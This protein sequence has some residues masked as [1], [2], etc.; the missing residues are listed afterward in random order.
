ML[1]MAPQQQ[2]TRQ[3]T[4]LMAPAPAVQPAPQLQQSQTTAFAPVAPAVEQQP[5]PQ[6]AAVQPAT[7]AP[8]V[9]NDA[10]PDIVLFD[11]VSQKKAKEQ[12]EQA[13]SDEISDDV[14]TAVRLGLSEEKIQEII[15]DAANNGTINVPEAMQTADGKI[16]T[17][18][19]VQSLVKEALAQSNEEPPAELVEDKPVAK[20]ER[21][22][23]YTVESGDSLAYLA[24]Q[25]YGKPDAYRVIYNANRS[26]ISSPD[27]IQIGQRLVIPAI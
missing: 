3:D 9:Q 1:Q 6:V 15:S 19:L 25:F 7:Q 4:T 26:K 10:Q 17:R 24:M 13:V 23:I 8:A 16:D 27:K 11:L 14:L 20:L 12:F 18:T 2:V 21:N 5:L 22:I